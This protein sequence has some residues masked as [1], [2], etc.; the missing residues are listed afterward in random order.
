MTV[1]RRALTR[2]ERARDVLAG[3]GTMLIRLTPI[4][5]VASMVFMEATNMTQQDATDRLRDLL[6]PTLTVTAVRKLQR[7]GRALRSRYLPPRRRV[8]IAKRD[9]VRYANDCGWN[10]P[11]PGASDQTSYVWACRWMALFASH[12]IA[13]G[14][15]AFVSWAVSQ[16]V[17]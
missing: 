11:R 7:E 14:I 6:A 17:A 1:E 16:E 10:N 8:D 13:S 5:P 9:A 3:L 4:G 15:A 12:Q 2:R